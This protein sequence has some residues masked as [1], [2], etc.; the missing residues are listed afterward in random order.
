LKAAAKKYNEANETEEELRTTLE[1]Y[2]QDI[3]TLLG[4]EVTPKDDA[5]TLLSDEE[6]KITRRSK[7]LSGAVQQKQERLND[8]EVELEKVR[9]VREVLQLEQKQTITKTL[10]E[11]AEYQGLEAA[12]DRLA[13]FVGDVQS[14]RDAIH[15][16]S[17]EEA[18]GRIAA[19]ERAIDAYFR[20]LTRH[21]AI[22]RI[23]L[24][25]EADAR[26]GRN[27]YTISDQDDKDLTPVLSQGDLNALALAIFLG[28]ATSAGEAAPFGFLM[29]D[30]P[31]Q[32]LGTEHKECFVQVLDEVAGSR[33]VLLATMDRELRDCLA[34]GLTKAKAEY[35][36]D[37]W[38][39][40]DGVL[41][42]RRG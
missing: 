33:R 36:F 42:E 8:I 28:L 19:A 35:V 3:G 41:A 7:Q 2:R 40:E 18:R 31:S 13:E 37:A 27:T 1:E 10:Q 39:P 34:E 25:V 23:K 9:L 20:R 12:R 38:T 14:I 24:K 17:Q 6:K 5:L 11:S 21:P 22:Y 4:R 15:A 16:A 29:L 32:S 26:S 30:D